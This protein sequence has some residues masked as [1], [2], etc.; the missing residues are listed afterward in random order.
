MVGEVVC[1]G[2]KE[3]QLIRWGCDR[4]QPICF[5]IGKRILAGQCP[6][7]QQSFSPAKNSSMALQK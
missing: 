3:K 7:R 2:S 5:E 1:L 4:I 6:N